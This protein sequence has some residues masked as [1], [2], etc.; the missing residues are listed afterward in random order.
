MLLVV[1]AFLLILALPRHLLRL[2][3]L[4]QL[5]LVVKH[6]LLFLQLL[7]LVLLLVYFDDASVDL[8]V[9]HAAVLRQ[10]KADLAFFDAYGS[11]LDV[12]DVGEL[13]V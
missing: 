9:P 8:A 6:L 4:P 7:Q 13:R 11:S 12:V 10:K 3:L 2:D 5:I 1:S